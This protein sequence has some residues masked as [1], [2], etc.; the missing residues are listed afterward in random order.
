MLVSPSA[1]FAGA[2]G[3]CKSAA[4][5]LYWCLCWRVAQHVFGSRSAGAGL[6]TGMAGA[7]TAPA[8]INGEGNFGGNA[9]RTRAVSTHSCIVAVLRHFNSSTC[10]GLFVS[11]TSPSSTPVGRWIVSASLRRSIDGRLDASQQLFGMLLLAC[12]GLLV[13]LP[14]GLP[15]SLWGTSALPSPFCRRL[16]RKKINW[17]QCC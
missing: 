8:G 10:L 9:V 16:A 5:T 7:A 12:G 14:R 6:G 3:S 4:G 2:A 1:L 17:F 13:C 15:F 11:S